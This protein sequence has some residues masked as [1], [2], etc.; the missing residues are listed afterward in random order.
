M[1]VVWAL[2]HHERSQNVARQEVR[3]LRDVVDGEQTAKSE[4]FSRLFLP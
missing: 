2:V 1:A 3:A 4:P